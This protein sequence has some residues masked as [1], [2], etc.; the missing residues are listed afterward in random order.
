MFQTVYQPKKPH[1]LSD[2]LGWVKE[3]LPSGRDY[4]ITLMDGTTISC[5]YSDIVRALATKSNSDVTLI[6]PFQLIDWKEQTPPDHL[7]PK[8]KV[9]LDNFKSGCQTFLP[10]ITYMDSQKQD[11]NEDNLDTQPIEQEVQL[12]SCT[13][14]PTQ[15]DSLLQNIINPDTQS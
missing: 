7:Y 2:A 4:S 14:E 8:F 12:E 11:A 15:L 3:I 1:L 6:D 13:S 10:A 9:F 5:H